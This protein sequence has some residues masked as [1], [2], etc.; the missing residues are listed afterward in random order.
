MRFTARRSSALIAALLLAFF[1]LLPPS[2]AAAQNGLAGRAAIE[3][4][5]SI[6]TSSADGID[7]PFVVFDLASTFRVTDGL[8]AIVRPYARR[9][10]GG[11]WDAVFYQAQIR[12]QPAE[13]VRIDAGIITSPMGLGTFELRPDLNPLV[14]YPFYYF[15]RL[16][17]F[18]EYN[19]RVQ[20]LSGGYPLGALVSVSG[21]RWDA[22][23][24]VTDST[25]A[26]Y[27]KIFA[28]TSPSPMAQVI[29]GGGVTPW[30]GFRVGGAIA[31]GKYRS[32]SDSEYYGLPDGYMGTL[33]DADALVM[34]VEAE[35]S[36]RYTKISGEW[37]RDRFETNGAP[38][39]SR[40]FYVQGA[41]TITPRTFAAARYTYAT[42]PTR[43]LTRSTRESAEV[44]GGYRLIPSLTLRA[45]YEGSRRFGATDWDHAAVASIVWA[46]RWF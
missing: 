5:A 37:V 34:N 46:Q 28:E 24:G 22:R 38:A 27:R 26:R 12:Y 1:L 44:S 20:I 4:V 42:T 15:G 8:D 35:F 7:D 33:T 14:G 18:D 13:R 43:A 39:V 17:A 10:P 16:P 40:G 36:Y 30:A 41:Q 25:P 6:A 31:K 19:N 9:L 23:A 3:A 45:G 2:Q 29:A 11:D 21:T 32:S